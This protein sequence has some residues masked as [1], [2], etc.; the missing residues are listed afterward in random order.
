M[1]VR[2]F[3]ASLSILVL[4][5][6]FSACSGIGGSEKLVSPSITSLPDSE[7]DL[8]KARAENTHRLVDP[9][10]E[11]QIEVIEDST[12]IESAR[13]FFSNTRTLIV[14]EDRDSALLRAASL[15]VSQRVP[16][17]VYSDEDRGAIMQLVRD[18]EVEQVVTVGK[19]SWA[20]AEGSLEVVH[21]PG[22][23]AA[24]GQFTAFQF[25]SKVV[26]SPS[27]MVEAVAQ[28][29]TDE[30]TEL[31]AAW[32]PLLRSDEERTMPAIEGQSRRDSQMAP[33][34]IATAATPLA[35]VINA[36][37]YGGSVLVMPNSELM[38]SKASAAMVIGLEHGSLIALGPEFGRPEEI[39]EKISRGYEQ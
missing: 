1:P 24:M 30:K 15:A 21:D 31:K 20:E 2:I 6:A 25:T 8:E 28:L 7:I 11:N 9:K 33:N 26:A 38:A 4:A 16:L 12:G 17:V 23:T 27:Q 14:A 3:G 18:L 22:T 36:N 13:T 5:A 10:F 29:D 34:M 37:A 19:V 32:E 39:S 35:N